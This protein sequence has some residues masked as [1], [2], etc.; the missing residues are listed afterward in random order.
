MGR[1][2]QLALN[3]ISLG[4]LVRLRVDHG[5]GRST[6]QHGQAIQPRESRQLARIATGARSKITN[7]VS[8][9][10]LNQMILTH[11]EVLHSIRPTNHPPPARQFHTC[12]TV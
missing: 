10:N 8:G 7:E 9:K 1:W 12:H 11:I 6:A 4:G 5:A 3:T 2:E